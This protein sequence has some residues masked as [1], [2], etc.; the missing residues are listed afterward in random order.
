EGLELG[1]LDD[2]RLQI[3]LDL[4]L[5]HVAAL[6]GAHQPRAHTGG[7]LGERSDVTRIVVMVD[8]LVAIC[9]GSLPRRLEPLGGAV[10]R[11]STAVPSDPR[12]LSPSR[13]AATSPADDAPPPPFA[14]RRN[15]PLPRS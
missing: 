3:D 11:L 13:R 6:R 10:I 1:V 9:H 5:H 15:P 7:V 8:H 14:A 12:P 4:Q 2:A